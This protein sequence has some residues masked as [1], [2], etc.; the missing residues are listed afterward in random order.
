METEQKVENEA[1]EIEPLEYDVGGAGAVEAS[2][3]M[4]NHGANLVFSPVS[5][6]I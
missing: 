1:F 6:Q 3:T 4:V 5:C 2:D